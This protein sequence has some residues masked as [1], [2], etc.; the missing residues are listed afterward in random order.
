[1][2]APQEPYP[3]AAATLTHSSGAPLGY[4]TLGAV[5]HLE[6][7]APDDAQALEEVNDYVMAWIGG[8]LT[9]TYST[10]R[11]SV[12]PFR[13]ADL[14][15]ISE[16]PRTLSAPAP[17][18]GDPGAAQLANVLMSHGCDEVAVFAQGGPVALGASPY[19]YRFYSEVP[20]P[21]VGPSFETCSFLRVTV[22]STCPLDDFRSAVLHVASKLRLRWG[23]AGLMMSGED[24]VPG[25][26]FRTSW[27]AHARRFTGYDVDLYATRMATWHE[28]VRTVSWL[29]FLGP[30]MQERLA[31]AGR[32][33][34]STPLVAVDA[35]GPHV[36]L[37]A[38]AAPEEGDLNRRK[39]PLAYAQADEMIR[40]VRASSGVDFYEPWDENSTE[41]WLRRF[42]RRFA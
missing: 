39:L 26:A 6:H 14:S 36:V 16:Y 1:M 13:T 38:G 15:V 4:S 11:G 21:G 41:G 23:A 8:A 31:A 30:T 10:L 17:A 27:F 32:S 7:L 34:A 3:V 40:P 28:W 37:T 12:D 29:S 9:F 33:L 18:L 22:P 25:R 20:N 19:T 42:E 35:C 24:L 5:F 2:I